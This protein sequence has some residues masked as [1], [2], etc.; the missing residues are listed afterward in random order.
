[1][2]TTETSRHV[3]V[4]GSSTGIGRACAIHLAQT[5]FSVI[6]GVRRPSDGQQFQALCKN[7]RSIQ[8][9]ITLGASIAA[10]VN[11]IA[12]ITGE[13]GLAAIVNNAGIGVHGPVE[14]VSVEDWRRQFEVNV[15]GQVA[16]T[17]AL[18]PMLR[19][20]VAAQGHGSGRIVFIGSI[21]GRVTIPTLGPYSASKC[22]IAA[23]AA[24][25]R[26]EL[27]DQGIFVSLLEP[28][29]I[30]SEIW[31]KGDETAAAIPPDSAAGQLYG[32]QIDA[33]VRT[34]R[35]SAASAI[36]ADR[37]ARLVHRCLT[38]RRPP[39]HK[40]VGRD[41]MSAVIVKWLLP[42]KWFD[43]ILREALKIR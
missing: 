8:L 24:A 25:L 39:I 27:R 9:D 26:L 32:R 37:V 35:K 38:A 42:E 2:N 14:F 22:A 10:A 1:M 4:T 7:L 19:R 36:G 18:L 16:V 29:A 40:T 43:K 3:L 17:Q 6:A 15:F 5:G 23:V 34:S 11:Q 30:Q 13:S 28:G 12:E 33:V 41:A 31:R 20:H 21:A